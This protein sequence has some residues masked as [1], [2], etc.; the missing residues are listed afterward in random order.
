MNGDNI[1]SWV[2]Q[3]LG[4]VI[5]ALAVTLAMLALDWILA[6]NFDFWSSAVPL[7]KSGFLD[8]MPKLTPTWVGNSLAIITGKEVIKMVIAGRKL[9]AAEQR[10]TTATAQLA[11]AEQRATAAEQR[12]TAA[13]AEQRA[14]E[15]E[16]RAVAAE[17]RAAAAEQHAAVAAAE[18]R[19][20]AA[21]AERDLL[22]E[23][24]GLP[25]ANTARPEQP[26]QPN[27]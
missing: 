11:E 12:A 13:E 18:Q 1:T 27:P 22:R 4:S 10:A 19:A 15:A 2:E 26:D 24:Q 17:Q 8:A 14:A 9:A 25:P 3:H 5:A 21:E 20:A 23:Q 6:H 16:Q 7:G